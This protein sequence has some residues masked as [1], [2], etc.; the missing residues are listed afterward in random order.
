[1]VFQGKEDGQ[2]CHLRGDLVIFCLRRG[3]LSVQL[4]PILV[5]Y[6][7]GYEYIIK[8]RQVSLLV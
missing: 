2:S 6:V 7:E 1:M 4:S 3:L 8:Y 5:R